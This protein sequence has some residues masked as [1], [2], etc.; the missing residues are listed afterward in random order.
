MNEAPAQLKELD[1]SYKYD[2]S[3][4]V[5]KNVAKMFLLSNYSYTGLLGDRLCPLIVTSLN[6]LIIRFFYFML[7]FHV[8]IYFL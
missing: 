6:H 8:F 3:N 4:S 5:P 1:E 7:T 2:A